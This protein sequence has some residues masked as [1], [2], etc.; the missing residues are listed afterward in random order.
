MLESFSSASISSEKDADADFDK[1]TIS[2]DPHFL[3]YEE[4]NKLI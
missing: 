4:M 3:N 2:N 1:A